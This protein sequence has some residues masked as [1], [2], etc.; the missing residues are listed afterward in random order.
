[1]IDAQLMALLKGNPVLAVVSL[2]L[3]DL[4]VVVLTKMVACWMLNCTLP[5]ERGLIDF[6]ADQ[7]P[8]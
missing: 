5:I 1:M 8:T 7:Q 3:L 4:N 2:I 6:V